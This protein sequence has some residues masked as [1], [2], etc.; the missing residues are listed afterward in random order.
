MT[1]DGSDRFYGGEP[2]RDPGGPGLP[3]QDPYGGQWPSQPPGPPGPPYPPEQ[4]ER[5]KPP[6]RPGRRRWGRTIGLTVLALILVFLAT[7]IGTYF[8]ASGKIAKVGALTVYSGQP[9]QGKGTNWLI[10]GSDSRSD[11]TPAQKLEFHAGS[12]SGQRSDTIMLLHYGASGPD[13]ISIPRDSYVTIPAYSDSSGTSHSASKN[14]INAAYNFGGAQLL[15]QTVEEATGV[16]IDH[17]LEVGF[18]GVVNVVNSV[19]GVYMCLP[20]PVHDSYSGANLAAGCQNLNGTQALALIRSRYSLPDSDISRMANQQDFVAALVKSTLRPGIL[21]NPFA[22][23][24]TLSS[25][26]GSIAVDNGTGLSDLISLALNSR[27]IAEGKG[28]VGT[29]PISNQG[30][31]VPGV[32]SSV[33]WN[34][35]A[36]QQLF[37][38]V[39]SD[40]A[41]PSGLL[42]NLS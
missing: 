3:G 40:T 15:V 14:K 2:A 24:P 30:Y 8:W 32:G 31:N 27:S 28:A 6:R 36:A 20:S 33:L 25:A 38:A 39:N 41:I 12:D 13:L 11:L 5:A 16:H 18:L 23:Y 4:P 29:V 7:S 35:T 42:N 9:A 22:F 21:F 37:A 10:V 26:F 17:Y 34:T 19:G 1:S